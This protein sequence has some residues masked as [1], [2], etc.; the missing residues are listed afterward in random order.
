MQQEF[1]FGTSGQKKKKKEKRAEIWNFLLKNQ[2][3]II[4]S[5]FT[6][7]PVLVLLITSIRMLTSAAQIFSLHEFACTEE[8]IR[9]YELFYKSN[10]SLF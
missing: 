9:T 3:K 7:L 6:Y 8:G 1:I 4:H 2:Y 5:E 10:L